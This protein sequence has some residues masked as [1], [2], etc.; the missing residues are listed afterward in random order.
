MPLTPAEIE[1]LYEIINLYTDSITEIQ[2]PLEKVFILKT[3]IKTMKNIS[4]V[5]FMVVLLLTICLI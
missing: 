3:L 5:S 1:R 4:L 2:E